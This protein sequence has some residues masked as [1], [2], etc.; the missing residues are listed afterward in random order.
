MTFHLSTSALLQLSAAGGTNAFFIAGAAKALIL[1]LEKSS[2]WETTYFFGLQG[3]ETKL[4]FGLAN[5]LKENVD[6]D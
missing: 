3:N 4:Q 1:K 5:L 6:S 2:K